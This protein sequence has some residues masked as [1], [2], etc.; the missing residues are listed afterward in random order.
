MSSRYRHQSPDNASVARN[1]KEQLASFGAPIMAVVII[2]TSFYA[3]LYSSLFEINNIDVEGN[4]YVD[5]GLIEAGINK[6]KE[7]VR[8][9]VLPQSN[10]LAFDE[11][12]AKAKLAHPRIDDLTIKRR[13][14]NTLVV[15]LTEKNGVAEW[16]W[17]GRWF[18]LDDQCI[19]IGEVGGPS[20][21][22]LALRNSKSIDMPSL[23]TNVCDTS[24]LDLVKT[25]DANIPQGY[26]FGIESY[27]LANSAEYFIDAKT[28]E[29]WYA[30]VSTQITIA[31]QMD[32][33]NAFLISKG[34]ENSDWRKQLTYID[35]RFGNSRI[36]YR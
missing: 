7:E 8:F 31:E 1:G 35:L 28:N 3:V 29:G 17:Q 2:S 23:G 36:Y 11:V 34:I 33:L 4:T 24:I 6:Q 27:D 18:E 12:A 20:S 16:E 25:I 10:I 15:S 19:V 30:R 9:W 5:A 13:L 22:G 26:G 14:P 21:N 32:K